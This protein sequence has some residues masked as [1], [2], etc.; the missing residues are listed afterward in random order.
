MPSRRCRSYCPTAERD[1]WSRNYV[2][3]M[4]MDL[5]A[6]IVSRPLTEAALQVP[7]ERAEQL[8]QYFSVA[9]V[10]DA[11]PVVRAIIARTTSV[12]CLAACLRVFADVDDLDTVRDIC[13]TRPGRCAC[14]R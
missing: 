14:R 6:D 2:L 12:E 9:H 13:V 3:G 11:V 7:L 1:D 5:G 4:L 10:A 8:V